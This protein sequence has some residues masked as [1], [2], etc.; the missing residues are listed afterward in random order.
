M[1]ATADALR[2]ASHAAKTPP[3]PANSSRRLIQLMIRLQ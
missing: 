1:D 2:R 3:A